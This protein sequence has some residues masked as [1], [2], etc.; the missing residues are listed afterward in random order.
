MTVIPTGLTSIYQP[1]DIAINKPFKNNLCKEWYLW[2][3]NGNAGE[4]IS[5][6]L[7]Y[8]KLNNVC[9]WIK[10]T[11]KGISDKIFIKSFKTCEISNSLDNEEFDIINID[12]DD[13]AVNNKDNDTIDSKNDNIIDNENDDII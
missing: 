13:D 7:H 12:N 6:N 9:R 5:K 1:L 10:Y 11:W 4:T 8:A 2:I 3:V